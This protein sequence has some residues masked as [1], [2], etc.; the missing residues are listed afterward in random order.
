MFVNFLFSIT[1]IPSLSVI[2]LASV[3]FSLWA[4]TTPFVTKFLQSWSR[5]PIVTTLG[6]VRGQ[7]HTNNEQTQSVDGII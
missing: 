6:E 3:T 5:V 1:T 4:E 7:D 2:S